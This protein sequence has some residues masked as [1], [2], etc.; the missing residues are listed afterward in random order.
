MSKSNQNILNI[1][2]AFDILIITVCMFFGERYWLYTSQIGFFSSAFI[3]SAS[4]ISYRGMVERGLHLNNSITIDD[5]RDELDKL[6]D[7]HDL[8]SKNIEEKQNTKELVE[9]VKDERVKL[10][11]NRRS[12]K[13]VIKDSRASF[14]WLRLG[15]YVVLVLGFFYLNR[16]GYLHIPSY[17][18]SLSIPPIVVVSVLLSE[19]YSKSKKD[20]R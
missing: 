8:Y 19:S 13:E 18:I 17:L 1:L 5:N 7:P 16:H 14:S 4:M 15:A 9:V 11:T 2:L 12:I 3:I 20:L 6:D 10:K